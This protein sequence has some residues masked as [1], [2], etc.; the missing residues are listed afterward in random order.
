VAY[1][2][3][4]QRAANRAEDDRV[5][6]AHLTRYPRGL[7]VY[8]IARALGFPY[9]YPIAHP[10]PGDPVYINGHRVRKSLLRLRE[11]GKAVSDEAP[12]PSPRGYK[13]IWYPS[14]SQPGQE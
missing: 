9:S 13:T 7:S 8:E 11:A 10:A 4:E 3:P 1:I 12:H 14:Q 6:H 2:R 5:I